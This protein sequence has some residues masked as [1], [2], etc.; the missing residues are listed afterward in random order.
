MIARCVRRKPDRGQVFPSGIN[1]LAQV[2]FRVGRWVGRGDVETTCQVQGRPTGANHARTDDC[3]V[4]NLFIL[5]HVIFSIL[6]YATLVSC[7]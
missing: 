3:D 5:C 2:C 4:L 1:E 6:V 7:N